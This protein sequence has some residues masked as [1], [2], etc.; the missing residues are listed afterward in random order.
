MFDQVAQDGGIGGEIVS[1][2]VD[3][4]VSGG[5]RDFD[6]RHDTDAVLFGGGPC[7]FPGIDI[8]MFGD[9]DRGQAGERGAGDED[10]DRYRAVG[11]VGVEME[12][13]SLAH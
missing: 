3:V 1:E 2:E 12:V 6:S 11:S 10:F 13:D 9:G 8:V 4:M 5:G 7:A